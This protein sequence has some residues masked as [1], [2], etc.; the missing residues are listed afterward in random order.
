MNIL[1]FY[2][3]NCTFK[4][5]KITFELNFAKIGSFLW[6]HT[7]TH[8]Y[9]IQTPDWELHPTILAQK[10]MKFGTNMICPNIKM[11]FVS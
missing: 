3:V 1:Q 7:H 9:G 5:E 11:E 2:L 8:I 4:T 10:S 6:K